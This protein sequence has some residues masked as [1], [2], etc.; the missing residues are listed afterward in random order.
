MIALLVALASADPAALYAEHCA[1]CHGKAGKATFM[2]KMAGTPSF[3][4]PE[5]WA[6]PAERLPET[7]RLGGAAVGLRRSM[8][9][10]PELSDAD[11]AALLLWI[12]SFRPVDDLRAPASE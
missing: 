3:V 7:L 11:R 9:A 1:G 2:G 5:F 12:E 10:Y 6:R 8:P 4:D